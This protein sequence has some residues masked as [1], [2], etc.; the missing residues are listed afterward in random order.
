MHTPKTFE[1]RAFLA[2]TAATVVAGVTGCEG[3]SEPGGGSTTNVSTTSSSTSSASNPTSTTTQTSQSP[4]STTTSA[5]STSG[6]SVPQGMTPPADHSGASGGTG[7]A[8][9]EPISV[10]TSSAAT[11]SEAPIPAEDA[12][13]EG[14]GTDGGVSD[15]AGAGVLCATNTDNGNHC[16]ALIIPQSDAAAGFAESTYTL[17]DGGTGHTH[18]VTITAYDFFYL[19]AGIAHTIVSTEDAG[20]T[21]ACLITCAPSI[22][23]RTE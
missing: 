21:H 18:T 22:R 2:S 5:S 4:N 19:E 16:H 15:D 8:T 13:F 23:G 7:S 9:S 17:E 3:T 12:C 20:H 1:R 14:G 6:P 10:D 11:S